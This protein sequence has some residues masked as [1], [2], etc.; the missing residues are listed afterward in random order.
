[1]NPAPSTPK[2]AQL[3]RPNKVAALSY[4]TLQSL[5][6]KQLE[7]PSKECKISKTLYSGDQTLKCKSAN[8]KVPTLIF[9]LKVNKRNAA[10]THMPCC[11]VSK[12]NAL[13]TKGAILI[14]LLKLQ[15]DFQRSENDTE[16]NPRVLQA[17][18]PNHF[19]LVQT[20]KKL[21]VELLMPLNDLS[22]CTVFYTC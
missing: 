5:V 14:L 3:T 22:K 8:R 17:L 18:L 6:P 12:A 4:L 11:T 21:A 7:C 9:G 15:A 10:Q 13:Q 2:Y 16:Q 20:S 1:M 19:C